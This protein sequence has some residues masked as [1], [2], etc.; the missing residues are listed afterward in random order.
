[1][2]AAETF[3]LMSLESGVGDSARLNRPTLAL[4]RLYLEALSSGV[5]ASVLQWPFGPR[6]AAILHPL[7]MAALLHTPE[8][9]TAGK[10]IFCD[11]ALG[12]RTL[13]YP[14]RGGSFFAGQRLLVRRDNLTEW[15]KFHLTRPLAQ[16]GVPELLVDKLHITVG[17]LNRLRMR[18]TTKPHLAHPALSELYPVFA[19]LGGEHPPPF[20]AT[21]QNELFARVRHGAGLDRLTDHR[22]ALS[23]PGAAPYGLFAVAA[24]ADYR[25][26]LA[27]RAISTAGQHPD[28]CI[29]DLSPPALTRIGP[30]WAERIEEFIAEAAKRFPGMPFF[31]VTQ[32]TFVHR[33][34]ASVLRPKTKPKMSLSR[35]IV[36]TSRDSLAPDPVATSWSQP[37]ARFST[38]A[39]LSADAIAALSDAARGSSDATLAGTLR[40]EMGA[41]RR[42]AS[43]PVGLARA[44]D[45]LTDAVGQ[46]AAEAFLERRSRATLLEPIDTALAGEI[47]GAERA[48]LI[49]ARNAVVKAFDAL[50]DETPIGS[51][52][53]ALI[54]SIARKSS[55]SIVIFATHEERALATLRFADDSETGQALRRHI[56][57]DHIRLATTDE[58]PGLLSGIENAKDR[59]MWKRLVL[60][61]P[62]ADALAGAITR[63]WLPGEVTVL[64]ERTFAAR[65]FE[66]YERLA[67]HPDLA[68]A[69]GLGARL[70]IVAQAA[71]KEVEARGA[72]SIDLD[73]TPAERTGPEDAIIDL[74]DDDGEEDDGTVVIL[75]LASGRPLRA[76]PGTALIRYNAD[77]EYNPYERALARDVLAGHTIVV[78]DDAFAEEAREILP[79]RVLAQ[80]MVD[81][82]HTYVEA[83]L[84]GI[85]GDTLSAK[86]RTVLAE[87]QQRGARSPS[88][89]TVL[90]WLKVSEYKQLPPEERRPHAPQNRREYDAFMAVLHAP[91]AIADKMWLEG[92]RQ[93]RIDRRRAGQRMAQAFVSVLVDPHGTASHFKADMRQSIAALRRKALDH[94]EQVTARELIEQKTH[95]D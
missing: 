52:T 56:D 64:C 12:C 50:N 44:Y 3:R 23:V 75:T 78:P 13:Y 1:M 90:G 9:K 57:K 42:A 71:K 86:A 36:R 63:P 6:D 35:V 39:G 45:L 27:A 61:A 37:L 19:A 87:I 47:G 65:L 70:A 31:A 58:L 67:A 81:A 26:A 59:N 46:N 30:A 16:P 95:H 29:V 79:I 85:K 48:R 92:I 51:L 2:A 28:I 21:P 93:L 4:L 38:A 15:N 88:H 34:V 22:D 60:I 68:G 24:D 49:I 82:Y 25:R 14:W 69:D 41:L 73:L 83:Q 89:G 66:T 18:D 40:R 77:A 32:D 10:Y 84:P 17:H 94:L 55:R 54:T 76:R 8:K 11:H 20:F 7:A 74:I 53:E 72:N 80:V 43:L 62:G 33:K 5:S 91:E